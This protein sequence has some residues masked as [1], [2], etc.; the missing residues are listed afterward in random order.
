MTCITTASTCAYCNS[1]L[2][3]VLSGSTCVYVNGYV[4]IAGVCQPCYYTFNTCSGTAVNNCLTC[5]NSVR[6]FMSATSTCVCLNSTYDNT[7]L[8]SCQ[9]CDMKCLWCPASTSSSC[10]NC[11]VNLL[12]VIGTSNSGPCLCIDGYYDVTNVALC[13]QCNYNCL[14]CTTLATTFVTCDSSKYRSLVGTT[15][16]CIAHYYDSG[17]AMCS[18]CSPRCG[19]CITAATICLT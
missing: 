7:T 12:R 3:L 8:Q 1:T 19:N 4:L 9:P 17:I 2:H 18:M 11:D 6:L 5:N 16:P 10:T 15:C 13:A 14:T